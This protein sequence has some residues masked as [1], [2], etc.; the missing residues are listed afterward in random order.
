[1]VA[2]SVAISA[3]RGCKYHPTDADEFE[4]LDTSTR[5]SASLRRWDNCLQA[6][7]GVEEVYAL[8]TDRSA[9]G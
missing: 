2:I 3:I 6:P 4:I 1:M 8:T 7:H 5:L 9:I